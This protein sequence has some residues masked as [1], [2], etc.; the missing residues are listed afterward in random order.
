MSPSLP[1]MIVFFHPSFPWVKPSHLSL[2]VFMLFLLITIFTSIFTTNKL[3][4]L[5]NAV[6]SARAQVLE[7]YRVICAWFIRPFTNK[8][9]VCLNAVVHYA[10]DIHLKELIRFSVL[11][12]MRTSYKAII[13]NCRL[14][15]IW[16]FSVHNS[17]FS[18]GAICWPPAEFSGRWVWLAATVRCSSSTAVASWLDNV[19]RDDAYVTEN[20]GR[21]RCAYRGHGRHAAASA[22][23]RSSFRW[24]GKLTL[25]ILFF[26]YSF[27]I[28]DGFRLDW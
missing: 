9:S 22:D 12:N 21:G 3:C 2:S 10:V 4:G 1:C 5:R 11:H 19:G 27:H 28:F 16:W 25:W 18:H 20:D 6:K 24:Q 7:L 23:Y 15:E 8:F 26:D 14:C 13:C 17:S